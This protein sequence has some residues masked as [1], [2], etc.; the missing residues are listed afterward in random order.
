MVGP[1]AGRRKSQSSLDLR[2]RKILKIF[3]TPIP[4]V[5][6]VRHGESLA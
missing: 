2:E 5:G 3:V 1:G 6:G 4:G